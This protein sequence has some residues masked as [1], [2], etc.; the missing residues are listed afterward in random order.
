MG[1]KWDLLPE[2][3]FQTPE[4]IMGYSNEGLNGMSQAF[5]TL[6]RGH[7]IPD[8]WKTRRRPGQVMIRM[9]WK[10]CRFNM[11]HLSR[12]PYRC[13]SMRTVPMLLNHTTLLMELHNGRIDLVGHLVF[14]LLRS[15]SGIF[16]GEIFVRSCGQIS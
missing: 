9:L 13:G 15:W 11:V 4:V 7:L 12:I 16:L 5:H 14:L 1:F 2:E 3:S 6:Y 8:Q 10:D